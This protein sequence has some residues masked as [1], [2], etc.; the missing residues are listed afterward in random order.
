M[1]MIKK[2]RNDLLYTV[3]TN[4]NVLVL[5]I[6]CSIIIAR[7]LGPN[8]KGIY[9][10][11]LSFVNL[12]LFIGNFG[13]TYATCYLTAKDDFKEDVV[14]SNTIFLA[15]LSSITTIGL[16]FLILWVGKSNLFS[17][18]PIN[19]I[20]ILLISLPFNLISNYL[21]NVLLG[22]EKI[23]FYNFITI[24]RQA[25][26]FILIILLV[27]G[28]GAGLLGGLY[29]YITASVVSSVLV[30]IYVLK[31]W[32]VKLSKIQ[33]DY[34]KK[35]TRFGFAAYFSTIF[36]YINLSSDIFLV[37]M[38][39]GS[40]NAGIYS[41]ASTVTKQI[42]VI[43]NT[44]SLLL[45]PRITSGRMRFEFRELLIKS[46]K[47]LVVFYFAIIPVLYF[48]G[49]RIIVLLFSS[50]FQQAISPLRILLIGMI[51]LG[52]WT[53]LSGGIT[54]VGKPISNAF[55]TFVAA[56]L[57]VGLNIVLIPRFGISGAA[58]SSLVSYSVLLV[59]AIIQ[60]QFFKKA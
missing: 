53:V 35:A 29:S 6:L 18:V 57:N 49:E 10:I 28:G 9:S 24:F 19:Y 44:I 26:E 5:G 40:A 33:S 46:L 14:V 42:I 7:F 31:R 39:L 13:I 60:I 15:I 17:N 27:V 47:I 54:G 3:F 45:A 11:T 30:I 36:S 16:A 12:L 32:K 58:Y 2:F 38:F 21:R 22:S 20:Y 55:S 23:K 59:I 51:P 34:L 52:I 1:P 4:I 25:S 50:Q 8:L 41:I 56:V 43:P 48:F 37:N